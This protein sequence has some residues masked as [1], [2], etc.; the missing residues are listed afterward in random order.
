M[1]LRMR[2]RQELLFDMGTREAGDQEVSIQAQFLRDKRPLS[3]HLQ[4]SMRSLPRGQY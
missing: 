4:V 2:E 1:D 3:R